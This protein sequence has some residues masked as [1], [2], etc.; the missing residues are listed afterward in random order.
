MSHKT[1]LDTIWDTWECHEA[2]PLPRKTTLLYTSFETFQNERFCIEIRHIGS[3]KR[4]FR[5]KPPKIFT[6]DSSKI[7]VFLRVFLMNPRNW[8]PQ[9]RCFVRGFSQ[10][11]SHVTKCHACH[12]MH[13]VTT[14]RSP[15]NA[16]RKKNAAPSV[17]STVPATQNED[18]HVQS[19]GPAAKHESHL[20]K[21]TQKSIAP[22]TRKDFWH[23]MKHVAMSQSA[24]PAT[25]KRG[26]ATFEPPKVTA[27]A[28]LPHRHG[29]SDL[30][31]TVVNGCEGLRMAARR[32]V[33]TP[34]TPKSPEWN[35]NPCYAFGKT[36]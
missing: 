19:A 28:A 15:D 1:T 25:R 10:F 14:W 13:V 12:A 4:L 7:D 32:L 23:V 33:N 24:T 3:P 6:L 16:I 30:T 35:V 17:K 29:H 34:S 9:N 5:M 36:I 22:I 2:P 26:C 11:S 8:L 31:Q 21:S 20:L 27:F 18:W